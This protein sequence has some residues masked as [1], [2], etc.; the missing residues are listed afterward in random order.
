MAIT[1]GLHMS[2][3]SRLKKTWKNVPSKFV[4]SLEKITKLLAT[5]G[6]YKNYRNEVK[7]ASPPINPY[8]GKDLQILVVNV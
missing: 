8:F 3:I 7:N 5:E 1:A 2:S 6:N 4:E